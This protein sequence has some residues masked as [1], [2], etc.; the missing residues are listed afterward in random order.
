[1]IALDKIY[2]DELQLLFELFQ[3]NS[4]SKNEGKMKKFIR[5]FCKINNIKCKKDKKGN[6]YLKKGKGLRPCLV[7]HLDNVFDNKADVLPT[8]VDGDTIIGYDTKKMKQCGLGADDKV[9]IFIILKAMLNY[10]NIKAVLTVEEEI[11][12]L[13]AAEVNLNFFTDVCYVL[14]ADRKGY[15]DFVTTA[16]TSRY[17]DVEL[18]SSEFIDVCKPVI[19]SFDFKEANGGSTDVVRLKEKG[20][21]ISVANISSGYYD[22]HNS[23][24][25]ISCKQVVCVLNMVYEL[26]DYIPKKKYS[27]T[28]KLTKKATYS[29]GGTYKGGYGNWGGQSNSLAAKSSSSNTIKSRLN[30]KSVT[31]HN[32]QT[33]SD[34]VNGIKQFNN[35][36]HI[37]D[38]YEFLI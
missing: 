17:D 6:L 2:K 27:H 31:Y 11:G 12:C 7:A 16:D 4:P 26:I 33:I 35:L 36:N 3:I 8:C 30:G 24:E 20:L 34:E 1:M 25:Y 38:A 13:G 10:E 22:P 9:G 29:W 18:S 5:T 21:D 23:T 37:H 19:S 28:A 32:L 15:G 14:Q